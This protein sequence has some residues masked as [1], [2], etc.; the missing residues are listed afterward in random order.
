MTRRRRYTSSGID[1]SEYLPYI[2]MAIA[3]YF[4]YTFFYPNPYTPPNPQC[5][6]G[7]CRDRLPF[8]PCPPNYTDANWPYDMTCG[9][10]IQGL[11]CKCNDAV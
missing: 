1:I 2:F 10:N 7:N 9:S 8:T 6:Y 3:A 11:L 5:Q 4:V